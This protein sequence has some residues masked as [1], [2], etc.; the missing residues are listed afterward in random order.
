MRMMLVLLLCTFISLRLLYTVPYRKMPFIR[1]KICNGTEF[2]LNSARFKG[3]VQ[4]VQA[5][6]DSHSSRT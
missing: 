2:T 3:G 5:A 1:R 4:F 6:C